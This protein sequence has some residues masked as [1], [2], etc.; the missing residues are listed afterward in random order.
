MN[1]NDVT[2]EKYN[3]TGMA[4]FFPAIPPVSLKVDEY[5]RTDYINNNDQGILAGINEK[6]FKTFGDI[7]QGAPLPDVLG[8]YVANSTVVA[9]AVALRQ[10]QNHLHKGTLENMEMPE[11]TKRYEL[12]PHFEI[13]QINPIEPQSHG[14]VLFPASMQDCANQDAAITAA[15]LKLGQIAGIDAFAYPHDGK[16]LRVMVLTDPVIAGRMKAQQPGN[17]YIG[18]IVSTHHQDMRGRAYLTYALFDA[19]TG[20]VDPTSSFGNVLYTPS[21]F[22]TQPTTLSI[23]IVKEGETE[24]VT[25]TYTKVIVTLPILLGLFF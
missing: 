20:Q 5:L 19:E 7:G 6:E 22:K 1:T 9:L 3:Q 13:K 18:A 16:V 23:G 2:V 4:V 17:P 12:N 15:V 25:T 14:E 11:W 21:R 24:S 8:I 10:L